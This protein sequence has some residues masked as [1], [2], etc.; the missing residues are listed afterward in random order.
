MKKTF[1]TLRTL[2]NEYDVEYKGNSRV[3]SKKKG[4][5]GTIYNANGYGIESLDEIQKELDKPY[6][7]HNMDIKYFDLHNAQGW[8][9]AYKNAGYEVELV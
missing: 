2:I 1:Y 7:I 5:G 4:F 8:Y 3:F 6:Q 9:D